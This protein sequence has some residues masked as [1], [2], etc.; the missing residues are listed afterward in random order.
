MRAF[1]LL[2]AMLSGLVF[3]EPLVTSPTSTDQW[4][5]TAVT[6]VSGTVTD[7]ASGAPLMGAQ[8]H[9]EGLALSA[10]AR[11]EGQYRLTIPASAC[12][13]LVLRSDLIV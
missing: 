5:K 8:I 11:N 9:V 12:S 10:L 13:F 7:A 2:L 6:V 1:S 3:G 4:G